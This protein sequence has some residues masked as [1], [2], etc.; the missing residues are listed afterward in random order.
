MS[1]GMA[2]G[3]VITEQSYY[4]GRVAVVTTRYQIPEIT[5][6]KTQVLHEIIKSIELITSKQTHTVDIRIEA[7]PKT[8]NFKLVTRTYKVESKIV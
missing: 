8:H 5:K 3:K 6:D 4:K 7:D 2:F 1:G